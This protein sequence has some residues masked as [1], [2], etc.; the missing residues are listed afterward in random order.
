[1][2]DN[3]HHGSDEETRGCTHVC[4]GTGAYVMVCVHIYIFGVEKKKLPL[5]SAGVSF[6]FD[7]L[8]SIDT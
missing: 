7:T 2:L 3:K 1:M 4:V 8:K 6:R 5:M